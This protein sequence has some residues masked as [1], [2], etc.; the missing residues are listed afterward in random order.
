MSI[1]SDWMREHRITEVE[2]IT[3][4]FTGIARGKIIPKEKFSEEDGM[5]LPQVVL[6][7]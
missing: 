6:T 4:D 2:C 1:I 5:R 7:S 3:P